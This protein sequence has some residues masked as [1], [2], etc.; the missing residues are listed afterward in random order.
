MWQQREGI[1]DGCNQLPLHGKGW[2]SVQVQII[3][4]IKF[5]LLWSHCGLLRVHQEVLHFCGTKTSQ[6][7]IILSI[8]W[9]CIK[10]HSISVSFIC[11]VLCV[12]FWSPPPPPLFVFAWSSRVLESCACSPPHLVYICN[13]EFWD[14]MNFSV[15]EARQVWR[16]LM[17]KVQVKC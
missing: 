3:W 14:A 5:F 4:E 12:R 6:P 15:K 7:K 8:V 9:F 1:H 10:H 13:R 11:T 2:W 16:R 17:R